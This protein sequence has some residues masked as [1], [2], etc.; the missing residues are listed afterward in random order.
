MRHM[1]VIHGSAAGAADASAGDVP[2]VVASGARATFDGPVGVVV[3]IEYRSA[4][5]WRGFARLAFA[6]F[7]VRRPPGLTFRR[8]M[9]SGTGGRFHPTPS[10]VH[11]G[12]FL[13]FASGAAADRFLATSPL[14]A[15]IRRDARHVLSMRLRA[16]SSRGRWGGVEPFPVVAERPATGPVASLTRASIRP[17][18]AL[19]FWRHAPPSDHALA[20]APGCLLAAGLGEAPLLR[21]ATFTLWE[22]EAAMERYARSGAHLEAIRAARS[23]RHFSEDMFTRFVPYGIEGTWTGF[24]ARSRATAE[25]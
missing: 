23:G 11:Q 4:A 18:K 16:Y 10:A 6:R 9:G 5:A 25:E 19:Q 20:D 13:A 3:L 2:D 12:M 21:Q 14:L 1:H 15:A 8:F 7:D 22:T 17:S 24:D